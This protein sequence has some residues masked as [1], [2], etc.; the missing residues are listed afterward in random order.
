ML[1]G[2]RPEGLQELDRLPQPRYGVRPGASRERGRTRHS[3]RMKLRLFFP[4]PVLLRFHLV[5]GH[6][7]YAVHAN[8]PVLCPPREVVVGYILVFM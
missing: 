7:S 5:D 1:I 8:L 6:R 3:E 4:P 2:H